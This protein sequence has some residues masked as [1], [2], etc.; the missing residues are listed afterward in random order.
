MM[1]YYY[2]KQPGMVILRKLKNCCPKGQQQDTELRWVNLSYIYYIH[3]IFIINIDNVIND[4][5]DDHYVVV[6]GDGDHA[7]ECCK[8]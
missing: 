8:H 7:Y 4:D 2:T 1:S 3:F 5:E 6:G